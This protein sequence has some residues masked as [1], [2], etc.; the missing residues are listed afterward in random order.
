MV[1]YRPLSASFLLQAKK[2]REEALLLD[3]ICAALVNNQI[4]RP[5]K[6]TKYWNI[7]LIYSGVGQLC[8]A[9]HCSRMGRA[10]SGTSS[11]SMA[12]GGG[13]G[14]R[15]PCSLLSPQQKGKERQEGGERQFFLHL[16]SRP[17][18]C[19]VCPPLV[20]CQ[21]DRHLIDRTDRRTTDCCN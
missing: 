18:V 2:R 1:K 13:K 8:S 4:R 6:R 9:P 16:A 17:S 19:S 7:V 20:R 11:S 12:K 21:S 15:G 10:S 3:R 14:G 5:C